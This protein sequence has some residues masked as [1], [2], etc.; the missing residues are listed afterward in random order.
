MMSEQYKQVLIRPDTPL[1]EAIKQM[2]IAALQ[3]LVVV[4][5]KDRL[6]GIVTDG[7]V[8][9]AI[10]NGIDFKEP[11]SSIMTK[12]PIVMSY[13]SDK[14]DAL[15]LMKKYEVRHIPVIDKENK[16]V[17]LVL[18]KDFLNDGKVVY[19]SKE[20]SVVIMAGGK[21]ARLDPFTKILPKPLI[22]IGEKPIIELI[23]DNFR[24]YGFNK[25]VISLSHKAE[26]IKMYFAENP[27]N[28]SIEYVQEE[29]FLGT[30][31]ALSLIKE[32]LSNTFIV[33]NCDVIT[34]ANYDDLL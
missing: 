7:D 32:R 20:T 34:D 17:G 33:S 1:R 29:N 11:V 31:G 10:I 9:R 25:F 8:R 23:M 5:N 16:V 4:D 18:W 22:P 21:G 19:P 15:K 13:S 26:M 24:K 27:N 30:I 28:Y 14:N 6:L 12:N 2:D 3:V